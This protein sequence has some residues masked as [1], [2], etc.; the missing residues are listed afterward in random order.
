MYLVGAAHSWESL[1]PPEAEV[2]TGWVEATMNALNLDFT[3][4]MLPRAF[5]RSVVTHRPST[6]AKG[7]LS[8]HVSVRTSRRLLPLES[9]RGP[10]TAALQRS[11]SVRFSQQAPHV[12]LAQSLR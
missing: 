3:L 12:A 9:D 7:G 8:V 4:P 10:M 2:L 1:E 6:S 11:V 5:R